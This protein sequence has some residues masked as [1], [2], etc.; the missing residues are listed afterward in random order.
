M[1]KKSK[2]NDKEFADWW[3][4]EG[5]QQFNAD[6]NND[7][8]PWDVMAINGI[9]SQMDVSGTTIDPLDFK[10]ILNAYGE[11][12]HH[13]NGIVKVYQRKLTK[14]E[15]K[16]TGIDVEWIYELAPDNN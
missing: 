6:F 9:G 1:D 8:I 15:M 14:K 5:Q 3:N 12:M 4:K 2:E 10:P 16:F 11:R 7:H 13:L